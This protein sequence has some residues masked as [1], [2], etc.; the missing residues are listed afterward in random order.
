M[1]YT[2]PQ[3]TLFLWPV[4][5]D[6]REWVA[7]RLHWLAEY[8]YEDAHRQ[9]VEICDEYEVS[10]CAITVRSDDCGHGVERVLGELP[11]GWTWHGFLDNGSW[12]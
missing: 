4:V 5:V 3:E 1:E 6:V 12:P 8:I 2:R 7:H 10:R 11:S 9:V